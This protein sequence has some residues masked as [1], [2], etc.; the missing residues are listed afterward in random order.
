MREE[1][2]ARGA[3]RRTVA[4]NRA[5]QTSATCVSLEAQTLEA[6][7]CLELHAHVS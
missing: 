1:L 6:R 3:R 5:R 4:A 7:P 2:D